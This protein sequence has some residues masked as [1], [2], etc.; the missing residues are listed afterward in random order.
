VRVAWDLATESTEQVD[1]CVASDLTPESTEQV[2]TCVLLWI[3]QLSLQS[4]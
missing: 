2:D 4:R 1:T 3:W